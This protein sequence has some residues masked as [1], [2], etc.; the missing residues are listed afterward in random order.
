MKWIWSPQDWQQLQVRLDHQLEDRKTH[1]EEAKSFIHWP[2]VCEIYE[3]CNTTRLLL[4]SLTLEYWSTQC[5]FSQLLQYH[6]QPWS[7]TLGT[8]SPALLNVCYS[9]EYHFPQLRNYNISHHILYTVSIKTS[10]PVQVYFTVSFNII[11]ITIQHWFSFNFLSFV[12][13]IT[14]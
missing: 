2:S 12:Y 8:D 1:D 11:S 3:V 13:V 5:L 7:C 9:L 10:L 6:G 4:F 14:E